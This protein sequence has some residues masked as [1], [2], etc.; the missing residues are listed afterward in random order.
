MEDYFSILKSEC[1]F[2]QFPH[3]F[4]AFQSPSYFITTNTE[5]QFGSETGAENFDLYFDRTNMYIIELDDY[6]MSFGG[7]IEAK[8]D[9]PQKTYMQIVDYEILEQNNWEETF[10][11]MEIMKDFCKHLLTNDHLTYDMSKLWT[12][13]PPMKGVR[14]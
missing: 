4:Q 7:Y 9:F 11:Q 14:Y 8:V 13:C 2:I 5:N 1:K 10:L 12:K 6:T 3:Y